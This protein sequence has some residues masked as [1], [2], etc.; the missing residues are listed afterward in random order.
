MENS[1]TNNIPVKNAGLA[2]LSNYYPVLFERTG[3]MHDFSFTDA[4]NQSKAAQYLQFVATGHTDFS[5]NELV[6][7][8]ILCGIAAEMPVSGITDIAEEHQ[9]IMNSLLDAAIGHWTA[10]GK[11]SRDAFRGN[12]LVR[13]GILTENEQDWKLTIEKR[14]YD[15]LIQYAPFSFSPIR[16]PWMKKTLH[17]HWSY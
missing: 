3:L 15:I 7:N 2:L 4:A 8:K 12:W 17:V 9:M 11:S 1:A 13:D 10:I 14:A 6:L 5:G 16:F